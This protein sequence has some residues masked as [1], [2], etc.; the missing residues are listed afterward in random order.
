MRAGVGEPPLAADRVDADHLA[1]FLRERSDHRVGHYFENL[2]HYW[3]LHVRGVEVVAHRFPVR[4]G[5]RTLGEIDF[6][7]RDERGR[8]IHREVAVKFYLQV[9]DADRP[10]VRYLGPNTT[11]RLECKIARLREH[12]LPLSARVEPD[13]AGR[14]M[15]VKGRIYRHA[16]TPPIGHDLPDLDPGH[17]RG[18]WLRHWELAACLD[19]E[20][21]CR[22]FALMRKP[23]WLTPGPDRMG[24]DALETLAVGH[25]AGTKTALHVAVL[26]PDDAETDRWF[27]VDDTWPW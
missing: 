21:E 5:E 20:A 16:D 4:D 23:R 6:L 13:I 24:R 10:S 14:E 11:D 15:F 1:A 19:R 8:L 7:F 3:L 9:P 22:R 26:G 12:Q 25:F 18:R 17:L 2:L 27:I